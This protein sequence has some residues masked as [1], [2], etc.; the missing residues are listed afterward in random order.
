MNVK[1]RIRKHKTVILCVLTG[2][3]VAGFTMHVMRS[4]A[5][6]NISVGFADT[7]NGSNIVVVGRNSSMNNVSLIA[8]N[9]KGSPSWVIRCLET[10]EVFTSQRKAALTMGLHQNELSQHLN[11][12]REQVN[13]NHFERICM[14]A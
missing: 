4:V 11:G 6:K 9:R 3:G 14:A 13:G 12:A 1:E 7:A 10:D 8:S 5:S 2:V